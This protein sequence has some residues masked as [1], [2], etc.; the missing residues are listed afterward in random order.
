MKEERDELELQEQRSFID[1]D[2]HDESV[3]NE[4]E[5]DF[6][7]PQ[8]RE[9]QCKKVETF[10]Q[11]G[12]YDLKSPQEKKE[13]IKAYFQF[14]NAMENHTFPKF[15]IIRQNAQAFTETS[16]FDEFADKLVNSDLKGAD[17]IDKDLMNILSGPMKYSAFFYRESMA[18]K[19][20][21]F[22]KPFQAMD[23]KVGEWCKSHRKKWTLGMPFLT[24]NREP[25]AEKAKEQPML[26]NLL[27]PEKQEGGQKKKNTV[28]RA[29]T[30]IKALDDVD[31]FWMFSSS[32]EFGAVQRA[33]KNLKDHEKQVSKVTIATDARVRYAKEHLEKIEAVKGAVETYLRRK[34]RQFRERG[35]RRDSDVKQ[36]REQKRIA[37]ML[38]LLEGMEVTKDQVIT[39]GKKY[40]DE[41]KQDL[42]KS[43]VDIEMLRSETY[44]FFDTMEA[45]N[46]EKF[47]N[48]RKEDLQDRFLSVQSK[49]KI[50][51]KPKDQ[52]RAANYANDKQRL[53]ERQA[54]KSGSG[55]KK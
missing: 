52:K 49:M 14:L 50:D 41:V 1:E 30:W 4:G 46:A 47:R 33:L 29:E 12:Q 54:I 25:E 44:K 38:K 55:M 36:K 26:D 48:E 28:V 20:S 17:F 6:A 53:Q 22:V 18:T 34:E 2:E 13:V 27:K 16:F 15:D 7:D 39:I 5:G 21:A 51:Y 31:P 40:V 24:E 43:G 32:T 35:D 19:R 10:F 11:S 3:E 37:T 8:Y 23:E 9:E 42:E 45:N